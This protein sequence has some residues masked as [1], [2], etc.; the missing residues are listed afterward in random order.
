MCTKQLVSQGP[1]IPYS[2]GAKM[3]LDTTKKC[4]TLIVY[5]KNKAS[6]NSNEKIHAQKK[7]S[8]LILK[9]W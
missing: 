9:D 2:T 5:V 7:G 8:G 6:L 3:N 4:I 1:P